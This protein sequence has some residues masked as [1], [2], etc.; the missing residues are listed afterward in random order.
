[1][2]EQLVVRIEALL[3]RDLVQGIECPLPGI[4]LYLIALTAAGKMSDVTSKLNLASRIQTTSTAIRICSTVI[5]DTVDGREAGGGSIEEF[6][7]FQNSTRH[8]KCSPRC[9]R[10]GSVRS[11]SSCRPRTKMGVCRR[12]TTKVS[13][14]IRLLFWRP[15]FR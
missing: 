1:M 13:R 14:I 10:P 3:W 7:S 8:T 11:S 5:L 9:P 6:C 15:T 2:I 4:Y 12:W